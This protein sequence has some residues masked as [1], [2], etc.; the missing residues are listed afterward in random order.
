M[1]PGRWGCLPNGTERRKHGFLGGSQ[2]TLKQPQ[3]LLSSVSR[4]SHKVVLSPGGPQPKDSSLVTPGLL[5]A[6]L[7]QSGTAVRCVRPSLSLGL[8]IPGRMSFLPFRPYQPTKTLPRL[9]FCSRA[10]GPALGSDGW[11]APGV[12]AVRFSVLW[13]SRGRAV[14]SRC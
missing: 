4:L 13:G 11:R 5:Q 7:G 2:P 14:D 9:G 8:H 6:T 1:Y 10:Q 12:G 3:S